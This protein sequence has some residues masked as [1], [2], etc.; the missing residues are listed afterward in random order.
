MWPGVEMAPIYGFD[1]EGK[2]S[3]EAPAAA[4]IRYAPG[5]A[6]PAHAHPGYEHVVVLEGSQRDEQ[7][8]YS[9]GTCTLQAPGSQHQVWSDEGCLVLAIWN[10]PVALLK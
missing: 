2:T 4:L 1:N 3:P 6:V 5:A 9:Q 7:H 8:V 10:R